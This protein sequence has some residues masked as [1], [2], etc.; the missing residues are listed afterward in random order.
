MSSSN[1]TA[2]GAFCVPFTCAEVG[3]LE[4][5]MDRMFAA[6]DRPVLVPFL[7]Y[8]LGAMIASRRSGAGESGVIAPL[9]VPVLIRLPSGDREALETWA[10]QSGCSVEDVI[11][12]TVMTMVEVIAAY[13]PHKLA[14]VG[15]A[16][17]RRRFTGKRRHNGDDN[18]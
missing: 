17:S 11:R 3:T 8:V 6:W 5:A 9:H 15:S 16:I 14:R 7:E 1:A 18:L 10:V 2:D 13:P 12:H 4:D